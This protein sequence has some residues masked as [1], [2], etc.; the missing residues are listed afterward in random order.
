MYCLKKK[1]EKKGERKGEKKGEKKETGVV[2][3]VGELKSKSQRI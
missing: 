2:E 1:G 3:T